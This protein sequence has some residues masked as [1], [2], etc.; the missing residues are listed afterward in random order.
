[1]INFVFILVAYLLGSIPSGLWI[2][3]YFFGKN[4]RELGSKNTGTT[5]AFR[6]LGKKAGSVT[7]LID[8]LKGTLAVL[9]PIWLGGGDT[10]SPL[11]IGFFAVIGHTFPVFAGFKGGKAVATSAG[12]LLGFTPVYCLFLLALFAV[13]LYL[14]SMISFASVMTAG[15]G[16]IT[17]YTFPYFHFI[18]ADYDWLFTIIVTAL[19]FIIIIR[20][21][22]NIGRIRRKEENLVPFGLNLTHQTPKTSN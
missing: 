1:M 5:N 10:W 7:F 17:L 9:L 11:L 22:D 6:I 20:H 4:L 14:S 8:M 16:L 18:L 12:V 21:K 19:A 3:R 13:I 2:G 15:L